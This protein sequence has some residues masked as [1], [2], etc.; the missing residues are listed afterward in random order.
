M[1]S[2]HSGWGTAGPST[3]HHRA[4]LFSDCCDHLVK[5][6]AAWDQRFYTHFSGSRPFSLLFCLFLISDPFEISLISQDLEISQ[7]LVK[8]KF[9]YQIPCCPYSH[10]FPSAAQVV[11]LGFFFFFNTYFYLFIYFAS[12]GLSYGTQDLQSSLQHAG[13]SS[14]NRDGNWAPGI[15]SVES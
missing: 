4:V 2:L 9:G 1:P 6:S 12:P 10:L 15:G 13:S 11:P 8:S 3:W 7:M 5:G 14:Q